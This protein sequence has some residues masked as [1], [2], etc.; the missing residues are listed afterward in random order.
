MRS[1]HLKLLTSIVLMVLLT[2]VFIPLSLAKQIQAELSEVRSYAGSVEPSLQSGNLDEARFNNPTSFILLH[3]GE[4]AISDTSNHLIRKLTKEKVASFA[5]APFIIDGSATLFGSFI[6]GKGQAAA[7]NEPAGIASD[8]A[9]NVYV[10]DSANHAIRKVSAAGEVTTI[11]GNGILGLIDGKALQ[12]QF[13]SPHDVAVDSK[14]NIYVADT[15]NH[16]I[17]KITPAGDVSTV[18]K[19]SDRVIEYVPGLADEVGDYADGKVAEALFN[20]PIAL[21][22]DDNDNLYVVD[23][24]NQRIRYIDFKLDLVTTVAGSGEL[25]ASELYVEGDYL[26]GS[27]LQAKFS[28]PEGIAWL[29]A[30]TLLIADRK[31]HT[32]RKLKAGVVSTV[33]GIAEEYGQEDGLLASATFNE[34]VDVLVQED[35][36]I[37]IL[38]A[39]HNRIRKLATYDKFLSHQYTQD[40]QLVVNGQLLQSQAE[41]RSGRTL[42]PLR[43]LADALALEIN[44]DETTREITLSNDNKQFIFYPNQAQAVVI[45]DNKPSSY[46]LDAPAILIE[47]R[48][49]IPVR[50][51]SEQLGLHVAWDD[52]LRNVVIRDYVL[53]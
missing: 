42:L 10:A 40:I 33:A 3:N 26:D 28:S 2:S 31:N 45:M 27:A 8:K 17:R 13:Y 32:I 47:N 7:F 12:A 37:L 29:D 24:G 11:A 19:P 22:I 46:K 36:S 4:I 39:G 25:K 9:G 52:A 21:L 15:L 43:A 49:F 44:Y 5:G 16:V 30:E 14:G 23:R 53:N 18:T 6:D 34:P 35:G 51:I 20:E 50:F 48:T 1:K 38:E 41:L